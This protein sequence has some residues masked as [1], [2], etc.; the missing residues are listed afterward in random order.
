MQ[1]VRLLCRYTCS[2]HEDSKAVGFECRTCALCA[3][4]HDS[5]L[6]LYLWQQ[7]FK[8]H[9][10]QGGALLSSCVQLRAWTRLILDLSADGAVNQSTNEEFKVMPVVNDTMS[11][12]I[13]AIIL[14]T[15]TVYD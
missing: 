3:G 9:E 11:F 1:V 15:S 12:L 4:S 13:T 2:L 10:D 14:I 5:N 7:I 8:S 6:Y